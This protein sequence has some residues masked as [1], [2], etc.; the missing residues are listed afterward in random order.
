MNL[1]QAEWAVLAK[2]AEGKPTKVIARELCKAPVTVRDQVNSIL[3]KLGV[4]NR[5]QAAAF[6]LRAMI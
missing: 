5:T 3:E 1:T 6:Y 2:V 4:E